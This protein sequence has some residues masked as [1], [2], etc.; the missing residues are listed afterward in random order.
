MPPAPTTFRRKPVIK[1]NQSNACFRAYFRVH[2]YLQWLLKQILDIS[3]MLQ[4]RLSILNTEEFLSLF[5]VSLSRCLFTLISF[6]GFLFFSYDCFF[7]LC[8]LSCRASSLSSSLS[9]LSNFFH[10]YLLNIFLHFL[11]A[12]YLFFLFLYLIFNVFAYSSVILLP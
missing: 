9:V 12:F 1:I 5:L 6:F 2:F 11:F 3:A 10:S 8:E 7:T 4:H